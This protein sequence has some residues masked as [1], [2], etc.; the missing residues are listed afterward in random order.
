MEKNLVLSEDL[1]K[2]SQKNERWFWQTMLD[3]GN[4]DQ[5]HRNWYYQ[6]N[7]EG[8]C[9][10]ISDFLKSTNMADKTV[11]DLGSGPEGFCHAI[12]GKIRIAVDPLMNSYRQ[13]GFKVDANGVLAIN[14]KAEDLGNLFQD[15]IDVIFCLNS[16][17]HHQDPALVMDNIF[18]AL[19][20]G[21][22]AL[23]LTDLRPESLLDAYHKLPL[24]EELMNEWA[25]R[26]QVKFTKVFKHGPGNPLMQYAMHLVKPLG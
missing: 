14:A 13:L 8:E 18:D 24:T 5:K 20:R 10:F 11:I 21:G 7:M 4:P 1:W 19:K 26:F 23:L 15:S 22:S 17:D 16:I 6:S 12:P 3:Q 9:S 25:T 2:D